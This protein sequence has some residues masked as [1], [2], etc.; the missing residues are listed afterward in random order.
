MKKTGMNSRMYIIF[1]LTSIAF[2]FGITG[3]D[4]GTT[5]PNPP[6]SSPRFVKYNANPVMPEGPEGT[7]DHWRSDPLVMYED[8]VYKMWFGYNSDG[9]KTQIGYATSDDGIE[10][11]VQQLP[12][13]PLGADGE[14]DDEDVETPFVV[15]V[16]GTYHMYY[17]ARGEPEGGDWSPEAT[18]RI[19][20]ATSPD[21]LTWTKDPN[22]PVLDVSGLESEDWDALVTAEPSVVY[23]NNRFELF[24]V[25]GDVEGGIFILE[26]GL[27]TSTDGSNWTRYAGNPILGNTT[28][29]IYAPF[30]LHNGAEY[31]LWYTG[32]PKADPYFPEGPFWYYTSYDGITWDIAETTALERGY[33]GEWDSDGIFGPTV[34]ISDNEEKMWYSGYFIDY[35]EGDIDFAI[36]YATRDYINP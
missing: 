35:D 12:A 18:Y 7:L 22:N 9:A 24:Y 4:D 27:A 15:K 13:V 6:V 3:C 5:T 21:G 19:G 1:I 16:E 26:L 31:E 34:L 8:D 20:H 30:V 2:S 32:G 28:D 29:N 36:G 33:P 17:C 14:W 10:W 25:G 11:T 23:R